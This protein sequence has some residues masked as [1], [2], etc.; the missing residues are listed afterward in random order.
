MTSDLWA[1]LPASVR[2]HVDELV[3]QGRSVQAVFAIRSSGVEPRPGLRGCQ[4][5]VAERSAAL[6]DRIGPPSLRDV[7]TL[8]TEAA[9]LPGP[10]VAVEAD[11]HSDDQGWFVRLFA[12]MADPADTHCLAHVRHD[13]GTEQADV[14]AA[15][16][17][18]AQRFGVPFRFVG[19]PE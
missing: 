12:V 19:A 7:D 4:A 17:E 1:A 5:L 11:W 15:G 9:A 16:Q 6:A 3:V 8:A 13:L 14:T 18:L 2:E 10:V